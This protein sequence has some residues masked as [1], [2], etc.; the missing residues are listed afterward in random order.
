MSMHQQTQR[1]NG[2]VCDLAH[3]RT[4]ND[5]VRTYYLR[6]G[7]RT[8]LD[9]QLCVSTYVLGLLHTAAYALMQVTHKSTFTKIRVGL[10]IWS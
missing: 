1:G 7:T 6:I 8:S 10:S 4:I 2:L 3:S 5:Y 9:Y